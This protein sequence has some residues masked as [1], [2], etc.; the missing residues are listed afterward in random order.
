MKKL[1]KIK[2]KNAKVLSE[3]DMKLVVGGYGGGWCC[4]DDG[5]CVFAG[6]TSSTQ[7]KQWYGEG[8]CT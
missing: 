6:C 4:F 7:C 3:K 1:G 8:W 5:E 2:L